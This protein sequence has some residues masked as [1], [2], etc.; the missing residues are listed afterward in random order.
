MI[1]EK[2]L[3]ESQRLEEQIHIIQKQINTLPEGKLICASNGKWHKWYH[4]TKQG[5]TYLPKKDKQLAERLAY[6]KYLSLQLNNLLQEKEAIDAYLN[7][8]NPNAKQTEL[9]FIESHKYKDLLSHIFVPLKEELQEWMNAPYDRNMNHPENLTHKTY[10]GNKVRSKSEVI[11]DMF[12]YKNKI[13]FRYE[14]PLELDGV[15]LYPDFTIRHP[16]TG[17]VY[18]WEHFGLME[19]FHPFI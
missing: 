17:Q 3:K 1:Y 13:P 7:H 19:S 15:I 10:S 6:K 4:S 18:Y 9:S 14:C 2:I 11:I 16:Q 8:Y 12:L 5:T